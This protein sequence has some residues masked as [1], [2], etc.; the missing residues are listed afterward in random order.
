MSIQ[1]A[2]LFTPEE[3]EILVENERAACRDR[4]YPFVVGAWNALEPGHP[5][6]AGHGKKG[7]HIR[8]V[9]DI[10]ECIT[11]G[12]GHR[13]TAINIPPRNMKSRLASVMW[14]TWTWLKE[15]SKQFLTISYSGTLA[16]DF[17]RDRITILDSDWFRERWPNEINLLR[18]RSDD[19]INDHMGRWYAAG[20][21]G[22]ITGKGADVISMDDPMNPKQAWS[23]AERANANRTFDQTI[24]PSRLNDKKNGAVLIIMQRLHEM[25]TTGFATGIGADKL[26]N[27]HIHENG[28]DLYRLSAI[29]E[30]HEEI[31]SPL[32]GEVIMIREEGDPIWPEFEPLDMLL[33]TKSRNEYTFQGQ[34]QQRPSAKGGATFKKEW[35]QFYDKAPT[36][37]EFF[38]QTWDLTYKGS[39]TSDWV[40]G[41]TWGKVG[42]DYYLLSQVRGKWGFT[43]QI[44]FFVTE[45]ETAYGKRGPKL[46]E[47]AANAQALVATL[48]EYVDGIKLIPVHASK[49]VRA[50]AV[51]DLFSSHHVY[52]PNSEKHPWVK[53]WI[54]ET[55]IFPNGAHDDQVD[56][57]TMALSY[58]RNKGG[59]PLPT[60]DRLAKRNLF[61]RRV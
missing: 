6:I 48:N 30:Q 26:D 19:V 37:F 28:W 27:W 39:M 23:E 52:V 42:V 46:V 8:L 17:L 5:F 43:D 21:D 40:V 14:P 35:I 11:R 47:D 7:G 31:R 55:T 22:T 1:T 15:P 20:M 24:Y 9:S 32:T 59:K 44:K 34:C 12:K 41:Q 33:E 38:C 50:D 36:N 57:T 58:L 29:A 2:E 4:L 51:S 3:Y 18:R 56:C 60:A 25:D 53:E 16:E 13:R 45:A 61:V 54:T 10:L 49:E